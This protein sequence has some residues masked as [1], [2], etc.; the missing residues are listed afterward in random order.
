MS[1]NL[2]EF[3]HIVRWNAGAMYDE[4]WLIVDTETDGLMTPVHVVE[5]AAQKMRGWQRDGEPFRILLNHD[6]PIDP[7]AEAV[8]GYS[9]AYLRKH[10]EKPHDAHAAFRSYATELPMVA[11]NLSFDWD[12]A[13]F[14]E[15]TRLGIPNAGR[16]GFCA[17]TLSRRVLQGLVNFKL[18][19]LKD[20]FSL[21]AERSHR[22]RQDV[23][24]L[25]ALFERVLA[26]KIYQS[27]IFGFEA[28]Q[29]FS[30]RTPVA[31][32]QELINGDSEPCWYFLDAEQNSH[33]PLSTFGLRQALGQGSAYVWRDGMAEWSLSS[34]LPEFAVEEAAKKRRTRKPKI[35]AV[36]S[37]EPPIL[38]EAV[39]KSAER[40]VEVTLS[41]LDDPQIDTSESVPVPILRQQ[42][43]ESP[44]CF[45]PHYTR[46]TDE[47][48]G[49]CRG[50]L[51]DGK[52]TPEEVHYL[53]NWLT[54][55][56]CTH[57]FPVNVVSEVVEKI[58]SDGIIED[59]ELLDLKEALESILPISR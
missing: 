37:S 33:G 1:Q 35:V 19:T 50:I 41:W 51:A 30:R 9:Q 2:I 58:L 10:G 55:C 4:S 20:H 14:P 6:V 8:H 42:A 34:E 54:E 45:K 32:C 57:I 13:L 36:A 49:L 48:I 27:G 26:P 24:T 56:P 22:G 17:L 38:E 52:V 44:L 46:W 59:H 21:N 16:R 28:V 31:R 18:E 5:I 23:E 43:D 11:Y 29:E 40:G 47:L 15:Y 7:M 53:H 25:T 39:Q 12:R 3:E